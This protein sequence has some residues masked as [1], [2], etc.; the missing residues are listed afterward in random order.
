MVNPKTLLSINLS[1]GIGILRRTIARCRSLT[2]PLVSK[3]H[4]A[5]STL[6]VGS[7]SIFDRRTPPWIDRPS[8]PFLVDPGWE[9]D[10]GWIASSLESSPQQLFIKSPT[11]E[12]RPSSARVIPKT[13]WW[14]SMLH[15]NLWERSIKKRLIW[16]AMRQPVLSKPC[17]AVWKHWHLPYCFSTARGSNDNTLNIL[18]PHSS[19]HVLFLHFDFRYIHKWHELST[20]I[21]AYDMQF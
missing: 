9:K 16:F 5:L 14:G 15:F 8:W 21:Q 1:F 4:L 10:V 2:T 7:F 13:H 20:M 3:L 19:S 17:C 18:N 6:G 12:I 11:W